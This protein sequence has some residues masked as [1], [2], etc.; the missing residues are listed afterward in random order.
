MGS[1]LARDASRIV[2]HAKRGLSCQNLVITLERENNERKKSGNG[3]GTGARLS[4]AG[5][6]TGWVKRE[7]CRFRRS[8][9]GSVDR[10]KYKC[11]NGRERNFSKVA[12]DP[13]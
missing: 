4:G 9:E 2:T 6:T 3:C 8:S 1:D 12:R 7:S 11:S 5:D 10:G 13:T